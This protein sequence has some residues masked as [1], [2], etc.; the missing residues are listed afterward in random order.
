MQNQLKNK[1]TF[2]VLFSFFNSFVFSNALKYSQ[3]GTAALKLP[4]A[5]TANC[6]DLQ[7]DTKKALI[8]DSLYCATDVTDLILKIC[9][10]S[11]DISPIEI[12]FAVYH[13]IKFL[14]NIKELSNLAKISIPQLHQKTTKETIPNYKLKKTIYTILKYATLIGDSY[15]SLGFG[16]REG[17]CA[18]EYRSLFSWDSGFVKILNVLIDNKNCQIHA[19]PLVVI[20]VLA[21]FVYTFSQIDS[22]ERKKFYKELNKREKR[23]RK[24]RKRL[25]KERQ[26]RERQRR[27]QAEQERRERERQRREQAEQERKRQE[28]ERRRQQNIKEQNKKINKALRQNN[29]QV[30]LEQLYNAL[31]RDKENECPICQDNFDNN[32]ILTQCHHIFCSECLQGWHITNQQRR[33]TL[34]PMCKKPIN[35]GQIRRIGLII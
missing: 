3:I 4:L 19:K 30:T 6:F 1:L 27:E 11:D 31:G 22:I 5:I 34:C 15:C 21:T 26:E 17:T 23:F 14:N 20:T 29:N 18:K 16:A 7:N 24:E 12:G 8:F 35:M 28:N 13:L 32:I 9:E 10:N 2:I 33:P 25:K